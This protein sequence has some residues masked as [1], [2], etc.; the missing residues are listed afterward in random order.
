VN[1]ARRPLSVFWRSVGLML[2]V[3]AVS[4]KVLVPSGFMVAPS[5]SGDLPFALVICT[6]QGAMTIKAPGDHTPAPAK[7]SHDVCPFAGNAVGAPAPSLVAAADVE[8]VAYRLPVSPSQVAVTPGR[9]LSAPP[10]PARGPPRL[11]I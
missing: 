10:L 9:G 7:T 6:G 11:L 2:A 8:F 5:A 1:L 3:F 4:M